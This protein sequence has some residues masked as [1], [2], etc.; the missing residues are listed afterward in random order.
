MKTLICWISALFLLGIQVSGQ[1]ATDHLR[2][3]KMKISEQAYHQALHHFHALIEI[4]PAHAEAYYLRGKIRSLQGD[5]VGGG[6]DISR[7]FQLD[8]QII[9][10]R[11]YLQNAEPGLPPYPQ[12]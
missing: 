6:A 11:R 7:A 8:P 4:E 3:G 2:L 12:E 9:Q 5:F 1:T 10:G